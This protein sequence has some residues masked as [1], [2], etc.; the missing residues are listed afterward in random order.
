MVDRKFHSLQDRPFSPPFR[1]PSAHTAITKPNIDPFFSPI[2]NP[3][4]PA[5]PLSTGISPTSSEPGP[6][7]YVHNSGSPVFS[8]AELDP[9]IK[10]NKKGPTK[11]LK[12]ART[13]GSTGPIIQNIYDVNEHFPFDLFFQLLINSADWVQN[14]VLG[15]HVTMHGQ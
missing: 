3:A 4:S 10:R 6:S 12:E 2:A 11:Y 9:L 8:S 13:G 15:I 5:A 7:T 14:R 1:L